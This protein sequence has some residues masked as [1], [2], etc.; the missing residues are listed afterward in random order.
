MRIKTNIGSG[1]MYKEIQDVDRIN[2][3]RG[4]KKMIKALMGE[5]VN[6]HVVEYGQ[7][8]FV[9]IIDV[10]KNGIEEAVKK[11]AYNVINC[12]KNDTRY[13]DIFIG[14]GKRYDNINDIAKSYADAATALASRHKIFG[15]HVIDSYDLSIENNVFFSIRDEI[16]V[17]NL[18]HVGDYKG[19]TELVN[20]IVYNNIA[21]GVLMGT[22]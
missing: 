11:A 14:I 2:V 13:C 10:G 22:W 6:L 8:V 20:D 21:R 19:L 7:N 4:F 18:L 17:N 1:D 12:F 16:K 15:A 5:Y 3:I 9:C